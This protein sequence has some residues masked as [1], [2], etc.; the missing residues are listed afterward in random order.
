VLDQTSEE[1]PFIDL[2][3]AH[4][5]LVGE[6]DKRFPEGAPSLK[7]ATSLSIEGDWTF[8]R[9]VRVVG[10]VELEASSAK[11]VESGAV[12]SGGDTDG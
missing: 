6:F 8:G 5:K 7:E 1:I 3:S 2:D 9:G 4:Y 11:R 12:L 10:D